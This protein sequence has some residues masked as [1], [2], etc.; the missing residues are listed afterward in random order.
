MMA[1]GCV[2]AVCKVEVQL[3]FCLLVEGGTGEEINQENK[4]SVSGK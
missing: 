2:C 3:F 1:C 4:A